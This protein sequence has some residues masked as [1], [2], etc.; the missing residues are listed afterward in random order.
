MT[1]QYSKEEIQA[2][3]SGIFDWF[4]WDE[5]KSL[6]DVNYHAKNCVGLDGRFTLKQLKMLVQLM[7]NQK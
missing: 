6:P 5:E 3:F 4:S 2:E 1:V 7:E